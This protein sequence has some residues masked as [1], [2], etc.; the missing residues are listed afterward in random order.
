MKQTGPELAPPSK[1][2]LWLQAETQT[3]KDSYSTRQSKPL[4]YIECDKTRTV[5]IV[6]LAYDVKILQGVDI[7]RLTIK[8]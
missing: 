8:I 6:S 3:P 1:G 7:T 4:L 2:R 5:N